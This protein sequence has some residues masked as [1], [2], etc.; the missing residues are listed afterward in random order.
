MSLLFDWKGSLCKPQ[1]KERL[2]L[3]PGLENL[4]GRTLLATTVKVNFDEID[5]FPYRYGLSG[6]TLT[7][8]LAGYDISV[9]DDTVG[10]FDVR[11]P[12]DNGQEVV[13]TP[14]QPNYFGIIEE[15]AIL[16]FKVP[17]D[18]FSF[19]RDGLQH[20]IDPHEGVPLEAWSASAFDSHGNLVA[21][22][23]EDNLISVDDI[24][25]HTFTLNGPGITSV[26]IASDHG[27][28]LGF[29]FLDNFI[30]TEGNLPNIAAT[31][32]ALDASSNVNYGYTI[33]GVDLSQATTVNLYWAS[34]TTTDTEI[35]GVISSTTTETAQGTYPVRVPA[36]DL[37]APPQGAKYLLEV[38]DP[39]N[40]ISPADPSK[41]VSLAL[42]AAGIRATAVTLAASGNVNYGYTISGVDLSQATTVNLYWASGTTVDTEIGRPIDTEP[43]QTALGTYPL[44]VPASDLAARPQGAKYLLAVVDPDNLILPADPSKV[45]SLALA[46]I[47][48]TKPAFDTTGDVNYG[49]TISDSVLPQ[50]TTV[51][52][53][54]A[55]GTTV[56]T[57][58][59]RPIDTEPT[60][61]ALGT[62][63]L[64]VPASDLAARPQGAKYLLA[65]VDPDNLILPAD[66][67]KVASIPV[68]TALS[69]SLV[70]ML[71][72]GTVLADPATLNRE[73]SFQVVALIT[74]SSSTAIH[75][76]LDWNVR[77]LVN[78]PSLDPT[79][80][81]NQTVDVGTILPFTTVPINLGSFQGGF[82]WTWLPAKDPLVP[83]DPEVL[84]P[85]ADQLQAGLDQYIAALKAAGTDIGKLEDLSAAI[86]GLSSSLTTADVVNLQL[87]EVPGI[88][89]V[90]SIKAE[91]DLA[92]TATAEQPLA[93]VVDS[94]KQH[95][96]LKS[97][98]WSV[99]QSNFK[100]GIPFLDYALN[101]LF[102]IMAVED[103]SQAVDP[104]D[105]DF[106]QITNSIPPP[107][108]E[109][110]VIPAG[111]LKAYAK[112]VQ[113]IAGLTI[114]E[115]TSRNRAQGAAAAGEHG[116]EIVQLQAASWFA[117]QT[118]FLEA[119]LSDLRSELLPLFRNRLTSTTNGGDFESNAL[120]ILSLI[121]S[122]D[123]VNELAQANQIDIQQQCQPSLP[124][125]QKQLD[126]LAATHEAITS[127]LSAGIPSQ[128]LQTTI[129]G[130][131]QDVSLLAASTNNVGALLGNL[132]FGQAAL[133]ASLGFDGG[134]SG[135][136]T[137]L[138]NAMQSGSISGSIF[139]KLQAQL[140]S[141]QQAVSAGKFVEADHFFQCFASIVSSGR[142]TSVSASTA[143]EL[144]AFE[145]RLQ[146]NIRLVQTGQ[147][148]GVLVPP[149][150]TPQT[151]PSGFGPGR[152]AFVTSLYSDVLGRSPE[153]AGLSFWSKQLASKVRPKT[154]A[155]A[156]WASRER[157]ILLSEGSTSGRVQRQR[158]K[159]KGS[160]A[161]VS[162]RPGLR[163]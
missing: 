22:V 135:L 3:R 149:I 1:R 86:E 97:I 110:S 141:A 5:A 154:V 28:Y 38:V 101:P 123:S 120:T 139:Q 95:D 83:A 144:I 134:I 116:W 17:L 143:N 158:G 24:P 118:S 65:V 66:L 82:T 29:P 119:K 155:R 67:S 98:I 43:T 15:L 39:N 76:T 99:F 81:G 4:E 160:G 42:P 85:I 121:S 88:A 122:T 109:I 161:V 157:Q 30:L 77:A 153:P 20:G 79:L 89:L 94:T 117:M 74:N 44:Q 14:S 41:V 71:P 84:K 64:Q 40:L 33:S 56:D 2:R 140:D 112:D 55:S 126:N 103:Y 70:I 111:P 9:T 104:P 142:G 131:L 27:Y 11:N 13:V 92:T 136:A 78:I 132:E 32:L 25:Q 72:D 152:D 54:W 108:P 106:R 46:G 52:L 102:Q 162:F 156:F 90:F 31:A 36:S 69:L 147:I 53:Y 148:G 137:V 130:F 57:E 113:E 62:Y 133:V 63:P 127:A 45:A 163:F 34:G 58:I 128:S 129:N 18:S 61:T 75:V 47:T 124:L 60:Q 145:S 48:P 21:T 96:L 138:G 93:L 35:G 50:A 8:Y 114:A 80:P 16:N 125:T 51:A 91:S 100:T 159:G 49:Y 105:A 23:S 10:V 146:A 59:G 7:N 26:Q 87:D 115:A 19:T 68:T 150:S 37:T 151:T 6:S 107:D 12:V 73:Q